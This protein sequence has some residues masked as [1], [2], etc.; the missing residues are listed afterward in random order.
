MTLPPV[1]SL[2]L[3]LVLRFW[4]ALHTR[5]HAHKYILFV[6]DAMGVTKEEHVLLRTWLY[7]H[8]YLHNHGG[9][10]D[11]LEAQLLELLVEEA[12]P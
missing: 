4:L 2:P 5:H 11:Y 12:H 3:P 10:Q 1:P 9:W 6:V 7:T 8:S